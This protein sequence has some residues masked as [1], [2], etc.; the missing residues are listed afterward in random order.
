MSQGLK[1]F[2]NSYDCWGKNKRY[3]DVGKTNG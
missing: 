3:K 1:S 2:D